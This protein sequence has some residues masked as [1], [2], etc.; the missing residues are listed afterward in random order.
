MIKHD[1]LLNID[2]V[3][4][5]YTKKDGV[6]IKYVCTTELTEGCDVPVDVFYREEP[7]P[8]FGNKYF[9]LYFNYEDKLMITNADNVENLNFAL[10]KDQDENLRYSRYRHDYRMFDNGNMIDGGRLYVRTNCNVYPY[11][12][13]DG[14]FFETTE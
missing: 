11:Q 1:P 10:V 7:H 3:V 13:R 4:D 2:K 12:I 8:E 14:D 9:G 5:L 6:N